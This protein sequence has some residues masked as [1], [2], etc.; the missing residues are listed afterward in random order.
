VDP[1]GSITDDEVHADPEGYVLH[2]ITDP[3]SVNANGEIAGYFD[4]KNGLVHGFVRRIGR[5]YLP[6]EVPGASTGSGLGTFPTSINERGDV[7][8]YYY[9][10][11][12]GIEHGFLLE[13]PA[14][15]N[16]PAGKTSPPAKK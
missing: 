16:S 13:M 12:I 15:P 2:A 1:P 5:R 8:G 11:A 7:T 14:A 4:D 6:F 10:G 9:T 3:L